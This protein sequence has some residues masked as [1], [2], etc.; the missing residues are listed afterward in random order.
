MD[1][2]A[3]SL[4]LP[5][6]AAADGTDGTGITPPTGAM[7][8]RGWLSGIYQKLSGTVVMAS[9]GSTGTDHAGEWNV[10]VPATSSWVVLSTSNA[11]TARLA[12]EAQNQSASMLQLVRD[13]GLENNI[14]SILLAS[15]GAA[16]PGGGWSSTTFKGRVR[17][18]GPA[19]SNHSLFED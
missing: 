15:T 16:A 1:Y 14:S 5:T 2:V 19:G 4:P 8:I 13:D 6:G 11:N 3:A 17:I 10:A 7:G 12:I 9:A 18:F